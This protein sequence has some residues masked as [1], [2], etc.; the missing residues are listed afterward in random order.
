MLT[1]KASLPSVSILKT[2]RPDSVEAYRS[3]FGFHPVHAIF[4]VYPLKRLGHVGR[5]I[6]AAP[7]D[8][9]VPRHLGFEVAGSVEEAVALAEKA[10]GSAASIA[11]VRQPPPARP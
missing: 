4:A 9:A 11:Y 8:P 5:V 10:H 7:R 1:V 6:V 2:R 3:R